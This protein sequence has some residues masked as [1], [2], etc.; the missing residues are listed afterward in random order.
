M[1]QAVK[2]M[3]RFIWNP[4]VLT[5]V[6]G[7]HRR[8]SRSKMMRQKESTE[9]VDLAKLTEQVHLHPHRHLSRELQSGKHH[10]GLSL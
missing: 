9:R 10:A 3:S 4:P 6:E 1:E 8:L 7:E 5:E 2:V